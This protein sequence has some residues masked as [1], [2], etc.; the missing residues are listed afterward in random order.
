MKA[1]CVCL[2]SGGMDSLIATLKV[3][4]RYDCHLLILDYGQRNKR[5]IKQAI[6]LSEQLNL[7]YTIQN[8]SAEF[9]HDTSKLT[10]KEGDLWEEDEL[11][12][13]GGS[14][15][16]NR[17]LLF[18]LMAYGLAHKLQ[19]DYVLMGLDMNTDSYPD[20]T[21]EFVV[22]AQ[23]L[24]N[25]CA[26]NFVQVLTPLAGTTRKD[27][28]AWADANGYLEMVL[29]ETHTCYNNTTEQQEWGVGCGD[30]PTCNNRMNY[31]EQFRKEQ[32]G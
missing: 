18:L 21:K 31:Y 1:G 25:I 16:P 19:A 22:A 24:I 30:C 12:G 14:F 6:R 10:S 20:A 17:N 26:Q 15:V 9:Q 27:S 4:D 23:K 2:F 5:E 32:L 13:M 7:P 11:T 28:F 8:I 3:K 29:N